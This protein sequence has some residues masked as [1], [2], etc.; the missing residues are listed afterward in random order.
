MYYEALQKREADGNPIRV[1]VIGAGT[2]GTQLIAQTC[3]MTGIRVS[4]IAE[5][6]PQRALEALRGERAPRGRATPEAGRIGRLS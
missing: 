1:G 4:A 2:F 3:R 6:N 5:L